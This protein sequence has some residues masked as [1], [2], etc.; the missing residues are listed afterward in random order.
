MI[1]IVLVLLSSTLLLADTYTKSHRVNDMQD[2]ERSMANIEAGILLND[3]EKVRKAVTSLSQ[4]VNRIKPPL[5]QKEKNDPMRHYLNS[6]IL[7]T[8]K[9]VEDI[10]K[11]SIIVLER[12]IAGDAMSATRAY[13]HIMKQCISCHQRVHEL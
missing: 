3:Q 5:K 4:E 11:K 12:M 6:K 1:K 9:I 13:S 2:M 10:D 8:N 7:F